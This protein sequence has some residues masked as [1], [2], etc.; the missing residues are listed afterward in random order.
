MDNLLVRLTLIDDSTRCGGQRNSPLNGRKK[1]M[2]SATCQAPEMYSKA[3]LTILNGGRRPGRRW[4]PSIFQPFEFP[5][6]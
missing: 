5:F 2:L 6:A 4:K 1:A 3:L